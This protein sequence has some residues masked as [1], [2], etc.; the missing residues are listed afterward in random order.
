MAIG[1]CLTLAA[2]HAQIARRLAGRLRL[3]HIFFTLSAVAV[4]TNGVIELAL[5]QAGQL[6]T[7]QFLMKCA[8]V[9]IWLMILSLAGFTW[10][11]FGTG[12]SR[13]AVAAVALISVVSAANF[14]V[15][16]RFAIRHAVALQTVETWGGVPITLARMQPGLLTWGEVA[17]VLL[18]I[19]FVARVAWSRRRTADRRRALIIGGSIIFFL[20]GS[21]AYALLVETGVLETPYFFIFPFLGLLVAMGRELSLDVFRAA[22]LAEKLRESEQLTALAARAAA[23][24]YWV[25]DLARDEIWATEGARFLFGVSADEQ[26]SFGRFLALL[27]PADREPVQR[28]VAEA[29]ASGE[30]YEME[31]RIKTVD[32]RER[33]IA[34]RGRADAGAAGPARRMLG[35]VLDITERKSAQLDADQTRRELAHVTRVSTMG[36]L[37]ASM[38]HELNQPLAAI[39]S[40]AQAARRFLAAPAT[41]LNEIREILDDIIKDDKRAGEVIHRLRA[42]VQ[43]K[44]AVET[45]PLDLN[46][47]VRDAERLLHSEFIGR[48]VECDLRLA[49]DLAPAYASRVEIQQVLLNLIV[50]AMDALREQPPEQ[51]RITIETRAHGRVVRVAV[52]DTGPG[53]PAPVMPDIFRP[54]FT[55]KQNGLGMGLAIC[56]SLIEALGGRLWAENHPAGGALFQF[57]LTVSQEPIRP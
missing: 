25:W 9:P 48:N 37:A 15:P 47:L 29:L 7:Y 4:A 30:D 41:D 11:Y 57:E 44:G 19:A 42:L 49:A 39:L 20:V 46:E 5:L 16:A 1:A 14:F 32:G 27:D 26:V 10:S 8:Q 55:T 31:Y 2:V 43:K 6:A 50:N 18:L 53:I 56:R 33:W 24:G 54:F 13:L 38:A 51:R 3:A 28:A 36:E 45:E 40:N 17:S 12:R 52:R 21:R 23:M 34:A 35:I 22:Q